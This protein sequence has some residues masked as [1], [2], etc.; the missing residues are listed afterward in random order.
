MSLLMISSELEEV[1]EGSDRVVVIKDGRKLGEFAR[2][3]A[4][5]DLVMK[6]ISEG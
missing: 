6:V 3:E 2:A 4:T 1:V 5:E